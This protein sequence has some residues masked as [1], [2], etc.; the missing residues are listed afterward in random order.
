MIITY[1][2]EGAQPTTWDF[3]PQKLL[4]AEAE[5]IER[6]TGWTFDEFQDRLMKGSVLAMRAL[7]FVML[8]RGDPTLK[9]DAVQFALGDVKLDMDDAEAQQVL[10]ELQTRQ[11]DGEDMTDEQ[12]AVM[13]Q[14][15]ER[16]NDAPAGT[17]P[18][19]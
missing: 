5:A 14:L 16:L 9:W 7:L 4:N 8:K 2:P 10:A 6:H 18:N 13:D 15:Y 12:L 1:Q 17:D 11:R 3:K 19:G